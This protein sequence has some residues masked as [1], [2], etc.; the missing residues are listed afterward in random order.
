MISSVHLS[1]FESSA[2][3][4]SVFP[5]RQSAQLQRSPHD[6]RFLAANGRHH[7]WNRADS[8]QL[9]GAT[10]TGAGSRLVETLSAFGYCRRC[11]S[12]DHPALVVLVT[13]HDGDG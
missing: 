13:G 11:A 5:E 4:A 9:T 7:R 1:M 2:R 12:D 10:K 8:A 6:L 3:L